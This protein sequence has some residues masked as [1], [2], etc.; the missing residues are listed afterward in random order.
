ML[1]VYQKEQEHFIE[2]LL[3]FDSHKRKY[4]GLIEEMNLL[5]A[6]NKV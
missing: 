1:Q 5:L 4:A 2:C 3:P 6:V